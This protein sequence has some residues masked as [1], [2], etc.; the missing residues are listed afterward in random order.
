MLE[1]RIHWAVLESGWR[2]RDGSQ[3]AFLIDAGP[4]S[5]AGSLEQDRTLFLIITLLIV[6][7]VVLQ[8]QSLDTIVATN[9]VRT[10][11]PCLPDQH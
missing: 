7:L 2:G 10:F 6:S 9:L 3:E 5:R 1:V 8:P 11:E 4:G